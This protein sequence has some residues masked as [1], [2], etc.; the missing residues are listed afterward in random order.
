MFAAHRAMQRSHITG[1]LE[2]IDLES[3][4]EF[5][6]LIASDFVSAPAYVFRGQ[7]DAAWKVESSLDRWERLHTRVKGTLGVPTGKHPPV[8]REVHLRAFR[9]AIRAISPVELPKED[10]ALT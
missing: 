5:Y 1:G 8:S 10:E 4:N 3:W 2:T 7:A 6:R 9:Q